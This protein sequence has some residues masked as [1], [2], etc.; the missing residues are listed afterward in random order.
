MTGGKQ[1]L[2]WFFTNNSSSWQSILVTKS[3]NSIIAC[4]FLCVLKT[5]PEMKTLFLLAR[6]TS[7]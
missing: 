2:K 4:S 1:R 3:T 7:N 5:R 6:Q